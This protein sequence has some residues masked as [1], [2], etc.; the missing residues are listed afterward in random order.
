[1]SLYA[2]KN[3]E[4]TVDKKFLLDIKKWRESIIALLDDPLAPTTTLDAVEIIE[5]ARD[6]K[7]TGNTVIDARNTAYVEIAHHDADLTARELYR[8][9][10]D[11]DSIQ[12]AIK[13]MP[14]D[15]AQK[16]RAWRRQTRDRLLRILYVLDSL[17][18]FAKPKIRQRAMTERIEEKVSVREITNFV[19]RLIA[20]NRHVPIN[21]H[22]DIPENVYVRCNPGILAM[23]LY[24][25]AKNAYIH[26]GADNFYI[27]G[28]IIGNELILT[29]CD[30]G[31]GLAKEF[32]GVDQETGEKNAL[33]ILQCGT[34]AKDSIGHGYGCRGAAE[35]FSNVD[36]EAT[37]NRGGMLMRFGI[38]LSQ[39]A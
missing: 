30:D 20:Q 10:R 38:Q 3:L 33:K 2:A 13:H 12:S 15:L 14:V 22:C 34:K 39:V 11:V 18:L 35:V 27:T 1:M 36:V 9:L 21:V 5:C 29:L 25:A 24:N 31:S 28:E 17:V 23:T 32:H 4:G 8:D 16:E 37:S 7:I 26:A 6:F 19:M